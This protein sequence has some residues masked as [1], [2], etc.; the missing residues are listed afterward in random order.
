MSEKERVKPIFSKRE[1][2]SY[3]REEKYLE[4]VG[5]YIQSAIITGD[6]HT[7]FYLM[8]KMVQKW[9]KQTEIDPFSLNYKNLSFSYQ[10]KVKW[11]TPTAQKIASLIPYAE[12]WQDQINE[13][14]LK[15]E[16]CL[17]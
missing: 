10:I 9:L 11:E 7:G 2:N 14:A 17:Q 8:P 6:W 3:L 1:L 13:I 4:L 15:L 12:D 16:K 5:A